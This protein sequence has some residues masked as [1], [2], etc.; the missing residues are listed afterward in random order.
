[1]G[2]VDYIKET[3]GELNHVAWPT[4]LQTIVY[5][6]IVILLS[7][8]VAAYLGFFDYVFTTGLSRGLQ[9]IPHKASTY[10]TAS[11]TTGS[12]S[13]RAG[14]VTVTPVAPPA[15]ST[16]SQPSQDASAGTAGHPTPAAPPPPPS[17]PGLPS[18]Q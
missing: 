9:F 11:T 15:P 10:Q 2:I 5:T 3:Q 17:T 6:V 16:H 13:P 8:F 18:F 7:L 12:G 1:M 4:R 14:G